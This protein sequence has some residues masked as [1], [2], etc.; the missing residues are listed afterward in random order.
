MLSDLRGGERKGSNQGKVG[1]GIKDKA[2]VVTAKREAG[3]SLSDGFPMTCRCRHLTHLL[4]IRET[5]PLTLHESAHATLWGSEIKADGHM[6]YMQIV[7][8]CAL[9]TGAVG[10]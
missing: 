9:N 5:R 10:V 3:Q 7:V 1:A 2:C 6:M 8:R 4:K